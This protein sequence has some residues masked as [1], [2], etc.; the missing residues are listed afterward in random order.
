M[1]ARHYVIVY[2]LPSCLLLLRAIIRH[3]RFHHAF[4]ADDACPL[5]R[6]V[7]DTL[8]ILLDAYAILM[9]PPP[10]ML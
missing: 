6:A 5:R 9:P 7:A 3:A 4:D 2:C 8:I 1:P 10:P